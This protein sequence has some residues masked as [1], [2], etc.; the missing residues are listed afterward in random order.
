MSFA[1]ISPN[2]F[3]EVVDR[4]R[5]IDATGVT[6]FLHSLMFFEGT[7]FLYL[8]KPVSGVVYATKILLDSERNV[9]FK[10]GTVSEEAENEALLGTSIDSFK[11]KLF[12][13]F[14]AKE[15]LQPMD[16]SNILQ[17]HVHDAHEHAGVGFD[18]IL[19]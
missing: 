10:F 18:D 16:M 3:F 6:E 11:L 4:T 12:R 17:A 7:E 2:A 1:Y 13:D 9:A 14:A 15:L 19:L 5:S 8:Y